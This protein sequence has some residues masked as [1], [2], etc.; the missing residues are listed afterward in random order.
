MFEFTGVYTKAPL[1][2]RIHKPDKGDE[3]LDFDLSY[4]L[5]KRNKAALNQERQYELMNA[6]LDYMGMDFKI[7][8]YDRYKSIYNTISNSVFKPGTHNIPTEEIHAILDMFDIDHITEYLTNVY[9]LTPPPM[10]ADVF[11]PLIES[12]DRGTRDQTYLKS[13]YIDLAAVTIA[14]KSVAGPIIS[15]G[16]KK[17]DEIL[18]HMK[19]YILFAP[20]HSHKIFNSRGMQKLLASATKVINSVTRSPETLAVTII[21]KQLPLEDFPI[22]MLGMI[23]LQK[24][25]TA[26]IVTD[27]DNDNLVLHIYNYTINRIKPV[28]DSAKSIRECKPIG[29]GEDENSHLEADTTQQ[30]IAAGTRVEYEYVTSD[31]VMM[32]RSLQFDNYDP[33]VLA[34]ALSFTKVLRYGSVTKVQLTLLAI[35]FRDHIDPR[36]IIYLTLDSI[37]NMLA[38]GFTMLWECKHYQMALLLTSK[39]V[40]E[41]EDAMSINTT[42]NK[43]RVPDEYKA[44]LEEAF[45]YERSINASKT[46]NVALECINEISNAFYGTKWVMIAGSK[47]EK[48]I[49]AVITT[50]LKTKLAE[51]ELLIRRG[52]KKNG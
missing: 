42:V 6:Y 45:P 15:Y 41:S 11:D 21:E 7:L 51:L 31:P 46:S 17:K 13:D 43:E 50:D 52:Y 48:H 28:G 1:T 10:L 39:V 32:L 3:V 44:L 20:I 47:Y 35:M 27:V 40:V 9:K 5:N 25:S 49:D 37:L 22:N 2:C 14:V 29:N 4:L 23:V 24:I 18:P 26:V 8:L 19:E 38:V 33:E 36:A 16:G 30:D 12:D 34:D